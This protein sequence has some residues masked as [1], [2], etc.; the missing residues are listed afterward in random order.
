MAKAEKSSGAS[1]PKGV[2]IVGGT[3]VV[4]ADL[5]AVYEVKHLDSSA[6]LEYQLRPLPKEVCG[7][8]GIT[9]A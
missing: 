2:S 7:Y 1:L 5:Y 9:S 8:Y 3:I 6:V 4:D